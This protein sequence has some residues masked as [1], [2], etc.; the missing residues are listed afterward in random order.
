MLQTA[1]CSVRNHRKYPQT[2]YLTITTLFAGLPGLFRPQALGR[3]MG[4]SIEIAEAS[5]EAPQF[6]SLMDTHKPY[7]YGQGA[8]PI[9]PHCLLCGAGRHRRAVRWDHEGLYQR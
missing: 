4:I 2:Y 9:Q 8:D 5:A 3:G 7:G 1:A 6:T